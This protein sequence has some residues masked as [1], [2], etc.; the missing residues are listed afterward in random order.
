MTFCRYDAK[1]LTS[2]LCLSVWQPDAEK[3]GDG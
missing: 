3:Q 1:E 2:V